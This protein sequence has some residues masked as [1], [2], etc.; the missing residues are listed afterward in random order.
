[1]TTSDRKPRTNL[2]P[3]R[4]ACPL[5]ARRS[6]TILAATSFT[7]CFLIRQSELNPLLVVFEDLHWIESETQALLDGLVASLES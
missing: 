6:K 1:M 4:M 7:A 3:A 2:C 5:L